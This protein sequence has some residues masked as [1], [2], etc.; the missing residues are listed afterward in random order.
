MPIVELKPELVKFFCKLHLKT[1]VEKGDCMSVTCFNSFFYQSLHLCFRTSLC[2]VLGRQMALTLT[3]PSTNPKH[4][5]YG[6]PF[7]LMLSQYSSMFSCDKYGRLKLFRTCHFSFKTCSI[8]KLKISLRVLRHLGKT[9]I[10]SAYLQTD[11]R[12]SKVTNYKKFKL[13]IRI[14]KPMK[15]YT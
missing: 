15:Q 12:I 14:R 6:D 8:M 2:S 3:V 9:F 11:N 13:P 10:K 5:L 4:R 1:S 7:P